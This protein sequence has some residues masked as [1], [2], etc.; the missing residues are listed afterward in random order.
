MRFNPKQKELLA[1]FVSNIG[2]AWFAGGI[3]GSVFNPSR[4]IYQILTYSLWGLISSVV[5]IMSG[6]LLI[7]K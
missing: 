6:I 7:R 3:I 1:S 5:F 4:D 2:V